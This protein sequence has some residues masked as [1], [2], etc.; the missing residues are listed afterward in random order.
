MKLKLFRK[1]SESADLCHLSSWD[2]LHK[3][4]S[5][6]VAFPSVCAVEMIDSFAENFKMRF[7]DFRS[8]ATNIRVIENPFILCW[9]QWYSRKCSL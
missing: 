7:S 1:E 2:V 3:D 6:S 8:R 5:V 9:S 4:G